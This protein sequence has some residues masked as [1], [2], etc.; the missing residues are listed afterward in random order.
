MNE[1]YFDHLLNVQNVKI[2]N[3]LMKHDDV[4]H[5]GFTQ[6]PISSQ[7]Q[8]SDSC[9]VTTWTS[10]SAACLCGGAG[11]HFPATT[12]SWSLIRPSPSSMVSRDSRLSST[13]TVDSESPPADGSSVFS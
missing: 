4:K 5:C 7:H 8:P 12:D 2:K 13:V 9:D 11:P 1:Y 6:T 10:Q 3:K